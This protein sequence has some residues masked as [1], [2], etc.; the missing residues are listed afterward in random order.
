ML[1]KTN[2]KPSRT[3]KNS[4]TNFWIKKTIKVLFLFFI[5]YFNLKSRYHNLCNEENTK[6][7]EVVVKE[8]DSEEVEGENLDVKD[9]N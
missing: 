6:E 4:I 1:E 8:G 2:I 5:Y 9:D 3:L 7:N